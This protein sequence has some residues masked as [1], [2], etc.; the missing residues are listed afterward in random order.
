MDDLHGLVTQI[1]DT[2][3]MQRPENQVYT[4]LPRPGVSQKYNV[5]YYL[6]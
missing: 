4:S 3:R 5:V 1:A 6:L 2:C